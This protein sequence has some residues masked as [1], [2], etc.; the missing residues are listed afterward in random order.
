MSKS[1]Q[2]DAMVSYFNSLL[3]EPSVSNTVPLVQKEEAPKVV[4]KPFAEATDKTQLQQL[5]DKVSEHTA[6]ETKVETK[7]VVEVATKPVVAVETVQKTQTA[8]VADK[9]QELAN[10]T[11]VEVK[12]EIAPAKAEW[13]NLKTDNEFSALFFKVAG[14]TLA[15]PLKNLGGIYEPSKI[16]SIF[17][18]PIWFTGIMSMRDRKISVVDTIKWMMP[19]SAQV[20]HDYKYVIMLDDTDWCLQCDEL[21]GTK[22]LT[23]SGIKWRESAGAR[24]W[25]AGIV[26]DD[27]CALIHVDELVG[28]LQSGVD[29]KSLSQT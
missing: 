17:G 19:N 4:S 23:R 24:P 9:K 25:L 3:T 1:N 2:F 21:I 29:V 18:K 11:A 15:V 7:P 12:V 13:Q 5:L 20:A 16:T 28:L 14:I 26:K 8:T 10:H 22:S 6:V 27:M